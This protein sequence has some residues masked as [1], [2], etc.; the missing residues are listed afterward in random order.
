[1]R[2]LATVAVAMAF[3]VTAT[4]VPMRQKVPLKWEHAPFPMNATGI[5]DA[6]EASIGDGSKVRY[7]RYQEGA[8]AWFFYRIMAPNLQCGAAGEP[9]MFFRLECGRPGLQMVITRGAAQRSAEL[10]L[11]F[12]E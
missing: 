2:R 8:F 4:A 9:G 12:Y 1:M 3:A 11:R 7:E 10:E 6:L 5:V